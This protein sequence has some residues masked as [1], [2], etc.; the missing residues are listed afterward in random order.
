MHE[1]LGIHYVN[2]GDWVESCTAAVETTEGALEI[3]RWSETMPPRKRRRLLRRVT[4]P[5]E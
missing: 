2:T 4:E 5:G 1:R 3:V